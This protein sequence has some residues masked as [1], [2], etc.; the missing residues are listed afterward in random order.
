MYS[1][2]ERERPSKR[3]ITDAEEDIRRMRIQGWPLE[4]QEIQDWRRTV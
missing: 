4:I 1:R 2:K 3:W